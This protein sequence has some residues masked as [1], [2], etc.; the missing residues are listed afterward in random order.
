[1]KIWWAKAAAVAR[2]EAQMD[3]LRRDDFGPFDMMDPEVIQHPAPYYA[4]LRKYAPIY[5]L[6][7][8]PAPGRDVY[9]VSGYDIIRN[10]VLPNWRVFSNRFAELMGRGPTE[11][12]EI[13]AIRGRGYEQVPTMLTEDPPAQR[14]YRALVNPAF[15]LARVEGMGPYITEIVDQLIDHFAEKGEADFL[16]EFSVPLPIYVIADQI[17]VP[18]A[19]LPQVKAWADAGIAGIGRMKGREAEVRSA[20]ARVEMQQYLV[21]IIDQRRIE[22]RDDIISQLLAARFDGERPLTVEEILSILQQLMVAGHETTTNALGGGL[23]YILRHPGAAADFAAHPEKLPNAVEEILRLEASTKGM[24]RIVTE[25]TVL[26]GVPI[27]AG[28]ALFLSYDA[29]NR[30][31]THFE[32]GDACVFDRPNAKAHLT[33]GAGTHAC[34]GATLSRKQMVIAYERLFQRLPNLRL[35]EGRNEFHYLE[36]ILHRGFTQLHI[37]FDPV[38]R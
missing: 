1:M 18:R 35:T 37:S 10:E 8:S 17:G 3:D 7:R 26:A 27:K 30:D 4:Q 33:F 20:E 2:K 34:V 14:K 31:E 12:P 24:W 38:I 28:S 25:D 22:P 23:V 21:R 11:D 15:T 5:K 16:A 32:N 13:A 36:S 9:F 6:P 19:D 29:A